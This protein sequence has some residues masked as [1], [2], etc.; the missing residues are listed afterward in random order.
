[1]ITKHCEKQ[2]KIK[3]KENFIGKNPWIYQKN[4]YVIIYGKIKINCN[5]I[6]FDLLLILKFNYFTAISG[7]PVIW[8]S[9]GQ[10]FQKIKNT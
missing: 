3:S 10:F 4:I 2:T 7:W 6:Y 5:N 8:D 1:M 9:T